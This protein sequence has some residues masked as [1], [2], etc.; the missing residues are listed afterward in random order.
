MALVFA[1]GRKGG[2]SN[3][4]RSRRPARKLDSVATPPAATAS[5]ARLGP[6]NADHPFA[7]VAKDKS[8]GARAA[9]ERRLIRNYYSRP[10]SCPF[11]PKEG[12]KEGRVKVP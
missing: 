10:F 9:R 3:L 12:V 11:Q 7:N 1:S 5:I 4:P 2:R 6:L 8:W